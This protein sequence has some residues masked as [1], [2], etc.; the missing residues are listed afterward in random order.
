MASNKAL[1]ISSLDKFLGKVRSV[2][3][4][5]HK[6]NIATEILKEKE[7][8]LQLPN[9]KLIMDCKTRWNS[10]YQLLRRFLEQRP[11][12]VAT[13]LDHRMKKADKKRIVSGLDDSEIQI[14]EEFVFNMEVMLTATL[15]YV[16]RSLLQLIFYFHS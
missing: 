15:V 7:V 5:F 4:Y 14:C 13:L 2:L 8:A 12:I 1:G 3:T 10:T 11:A 6:S 16:K 9:H